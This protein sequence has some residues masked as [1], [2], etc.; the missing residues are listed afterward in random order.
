MNFFGLP[1]IVILSWFTI[2]SAAC[3][4]PTKEDNSSAPAKL[5]AEEATVSSGSQEVKR[6]VL[7]E[8]LVAQ[9]GE[10]LSEAIQVT[11]GSSKGFIN[12]TSK[13]KSTKG[14]SSSIILAEK[15]HEGIDVVEIEL[16]YNDSAGKRTEAVGS[17]YYDA[18]TK[19]VTITRLC[20]EEFAD[21]CEMDYQ[22]NKITLKAAE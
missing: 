6:Y 10:D 7:D 17:A 11:P 5:T 20:N 4:T 22:K 3:T 15:W 13:E 8:D 1:V 2:L 19:T 9:V 12:L 21:V 18:E 16:Q 14:N